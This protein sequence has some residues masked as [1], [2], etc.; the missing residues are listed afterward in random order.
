MNHSIPTLAEYVLNRLAD[1]GID[2]VFGVPGDYAFPFDDAIEASERLQ[3]I[4]CANELNAAYAA[5]GYA[6]IKGVMGARAQRLPVFHIVGAPSSRIQKQ[7]LIT[8]HTLGDGVFNNFQ[9]L[10]AS[11]SMKKEGVRFAYHSDSPVS[12][13]GPLK[14]RKLES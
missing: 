11:A 7:G 1:L 5:D 4:V 10:S 14:Y 6:R 2:R 3:W 9:H 12:P 8:H 13:Y